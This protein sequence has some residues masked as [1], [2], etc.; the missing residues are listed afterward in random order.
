[1]TPHIGA[2]PASVLKQAAQPSAAC[3]VLA[4]L[5]NALLSLAGGD[6][7]LR[8][9]TGWNKRIAEEAATEHGA[10]PG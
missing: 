5:A 9:L 10:L 8:R 2:S 6:G 1:M 7:R 3:S 4:G